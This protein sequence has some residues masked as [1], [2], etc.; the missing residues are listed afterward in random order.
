M[1]DT[2]RYFICLYFLDSARAERVICYFPDESPTGLGPREV[3]LSSRAQ[4]PLAAEEEVH[5]A[6]QGQVPGERAG[7]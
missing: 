6:P 2:Q 1:I 4:A 3:Q 7:Q 5:G